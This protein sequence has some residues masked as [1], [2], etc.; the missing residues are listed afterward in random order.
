MPNKSEIKVQPAYYQKYLPLI[1]QEELFDALYA[2]LNAIK[3][4]DVSLL[5]SIGTK[6]Y[7]PGKWTIANILQHLIDTERI[8]EFRALSFARGDAAQ[9]PGMDENAYGSNAGANARNLE[10]IIS[11]FITVRNATISLFKSFSKEAMFNTG[12]AN[13]TENSVLALGF[14]IAGHQIHHFNVIRERYY[15]LV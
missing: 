13:N 5:K 11:E 10:D 1:E 14:F 2:A 8:F 3:S 9:L 15:N 4:L 7:A 6:V 12:F